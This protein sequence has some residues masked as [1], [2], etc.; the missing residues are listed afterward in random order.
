MTSFRR[1]KVQ[2][3]HLAC[4]HH[5][6]TPECIPSFAVATG[7][8]QAVALSIVIRPVGLLPLLREADHVTYLFYIAFLEMTRL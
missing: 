8:G 7:A 1:P 6:G 5:L 4:A 3:V 2:R